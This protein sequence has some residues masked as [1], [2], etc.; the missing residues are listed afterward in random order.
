MLWSRLES[1]A[2]ADGRGL[3]YAEKAWCLT[4]DG[5]PYYYDTIKFGD[6]YYISCA[7]EEPC[8]QSA[9]QIMVF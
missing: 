3:A 5:E 7:A 6:E 2:K 4:R 8:R 9:P 1:A